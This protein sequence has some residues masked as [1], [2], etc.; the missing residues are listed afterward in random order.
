[1]NIN[2]QFYFD[3]RLYFLFNN[4]KLMPGFLTF[5]NKIKIKVNT[6]LTSHPD[7]ICQVITNFNFIY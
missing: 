2:K 6:K 1:M 7:K 4:F 3:H 5:K